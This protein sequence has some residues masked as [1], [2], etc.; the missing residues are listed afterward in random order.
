MRAVDLLDRTPPKADHRIAYGVLPLQF[1]DLWMP[2]VAVGKR[3]PV[4][5][6]VHGGWWQ[7]QYDLSYAGFLCQAMK[8]LGVAVWSVEYRR[9]GDDGG[10][11]PGTMQ[12]VAAGLD[13]VAE[14]AKAYP[15]DV[16]RVVAAGHSAGGHLVFWLAGRHHVAEGSPLAQPKPRVAL[17]GVVAL[18]GAVDLRLV[19]ELGGLFRFSEGKP[20]VISLM[21][22]TPA[23]V[24][25]RYRAA[26]PGEL[27]P[28]GVA[29]VLV[30][31]TEDS[32]IPPELPQRWAAEARK[33]GDAVEVSILAG[34][35]HFDIVD[36]ESAAWMVS[37]DS[38]LKLLRR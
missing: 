21:G 20:A 30:Q 25:E 4:L 34:A 38:M 17:Q 31:G 10:G 27:L 32:Q 6:F 35:S 19:I 24:P 28:L 15:L 1:G 14:L 16:E 9:V 12:D 23:E 26:D 2:A 5:V 7:A 33:Q 3:C 22:G 37:R 11:W 13:H 36:P 29:Q 18:A 8:A